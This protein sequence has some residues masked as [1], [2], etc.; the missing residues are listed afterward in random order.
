MTA[1]TAPSAAPAYAIKCWMDDN[2][3]YAELPSLNQPCV[4]KFPISEGGLA[5]CLAVLG[6]RHSVE[7]HGAA[8]IHRPALNKKLMAAGVTVKDMER[9]E[10][11][12][13]RVGVLK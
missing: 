7:G 5:K 3:V 6:A 8:Y 10:A 4:L 11:V 1:S 9:A 12:L 13:K 2:N